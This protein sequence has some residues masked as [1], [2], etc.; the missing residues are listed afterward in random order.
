VKFNGQDI[1]KLEISGELNFL[2]KLKKSRDK[3][4]FF[5]WYK[6]LN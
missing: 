2:N 5:Y 4:V 1:S 6:A 3:A